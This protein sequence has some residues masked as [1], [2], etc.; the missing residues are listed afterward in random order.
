MQRHLRLAALPLLIFWAAGAEAAPRITIAPITG[1]KRSTVQSQISAALCKQNTCVASTRVFT[2][3]KPDWKKIQS[4]NVQGLLVGGIAK[5]KSGGG[6]ELQLSWLNRPGKAAQS[7]AFPLTKQ[8]KLTTSSLQQLSGDVSNLATGA[9]APIIPPGGDSSVAA[10][11][12]A[13]AAAVAAAQTPP[14]PPPEPLPLPVTPTPPPPTGE[15]TLAD[16]PVAKDAGADVGAEGPRHQW[17]FALEVG[18]DLLNRD[19]SYDTSNTLR[20]YSVGLF[21]APHARLELYPIA[22]FSDGFFAGIGLFGDYAMSLGLKSNFP[23]GTQD[24]GTSYTRWQAGLEWRLR[25]WKDSDFAIVPF[26]SYLKQKFTT[27]GDPSGIGFDGLPQFDL[28]GY[29]M[30]LRFDIPIS[31]SFWIIVGADYVLWTTKSVGI[32]AAD[33]TL[34]TPPSAG[35]GHAIEAELG[36]NIGIVGPLSIRIFG[37]YSATSFSFDDPANNANS[38]TD[39]YLGGRVMLR[40]QF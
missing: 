27:D 7:W 29:R 26:G 13:G 8:G 9:A 40:L 12:A 33:G 3:K 25:F 6:K 20:P 28:S 4:A 36:V 5:A 39:R 38:A 14:G 23:G 16:T 17:R 30:G 21:V 35:S 32:Q 24:K 18:A 11:V 1:D 31:G 2:K 19:L 15:K 37:L 10:G 22:F 34:K